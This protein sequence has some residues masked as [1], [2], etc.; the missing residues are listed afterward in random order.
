MQLTRHDRSE[1]AE[2]MD[3]LDVEADVWRDVPNVAD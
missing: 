2:P 1:T 3:R